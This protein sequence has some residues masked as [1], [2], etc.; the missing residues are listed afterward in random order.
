LG[1]HSRRPG[2]VANIAGNVVLGAIALLVAHG[3]VVVAPF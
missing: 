2:E 3:R 1:G